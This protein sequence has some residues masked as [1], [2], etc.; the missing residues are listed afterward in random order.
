MTEDTKDIK[1]PKVKGQNKDRKVN[2]VEIYS[3]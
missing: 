2:F 3:S 1:H